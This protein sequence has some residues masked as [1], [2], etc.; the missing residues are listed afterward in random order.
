LG[1][2]PFFWLQIC[3][4]SL[5]NHGFWEVFNI[6]HA[7]MMEVYIGIWLQHIISYNVKQCALPLS[8]V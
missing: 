1:I 5:P 3:V 4:N 2:L 8:L 6:R 7:K